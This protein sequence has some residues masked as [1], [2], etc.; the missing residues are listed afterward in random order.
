MFRRVCFTVFTGC[1]RAS[2]HT[3][4]IAVK[5]VRA[6]S[7]FL[8]TACLVGISACTPLFYNREF[9][10][11]SHSREKRASDASCSIDR[12][13]D[14]Y[15]LGIRL[16]IYL[17]WITAI[18]ANLFSEPSIDGNL[19][20]NTIFLLAVFIAIVITTAEKTVQSAELLVL[21]QIGF[22][23]T[24]SVLTIWVCGSSSFVFL[25]VRI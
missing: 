22:G 20:T 12:N 23:F 10:I 16:G 9:R 13:P 1:L 11:P 25:R 7:Q 14:F 18:G 5:M 15:G 21:L 2:R 8:L 19:E 24:F 3:H 6:S 4:L 17:Q